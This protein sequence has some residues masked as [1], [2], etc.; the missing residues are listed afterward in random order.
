MK[1]IGRTYTKTLSFLPS[2]DLLAQILVCEGLDKYMTG[3]TIDQTS[4]ED[5]VH[6]ILDGQQYVDVEYQTA[7][8]KTVVQQQAIQEE[9]DI[10]AIL[11]QHEDKLK[12]VY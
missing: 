9:N 6:R 2:K 1:V 11:E 7:R 8:L 3:K 5:L 10:G 4:K 12:Q